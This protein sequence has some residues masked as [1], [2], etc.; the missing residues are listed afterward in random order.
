MINDM[1]T[2][3]LKWG[4]P[5][6]KELE[7]RDIQFIFD[8]SKIPTNNKYYK[9]LNCQSL[10]CE[11]NDVKFCLY[12]FTNEEIIFCMEFFKPNNSLLSITNNLPHMKL[13]LLN[14]TDVRLRKLGIASYYIKKLQEYCIKENLHYIEISPNPN[15]K[16]F[17]NQS[18]EN[19]LQ[20]EDLKKFYLSKSTKEMP[21]KLTLI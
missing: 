17:K 14:V 7:N 3:I 8:S 10:K 18:K 11:K 13:Q 12:D 20:L 1:Y 15:A 2:T 16:D 5:Q 6:I 19:A 21:I 9:S 4:I